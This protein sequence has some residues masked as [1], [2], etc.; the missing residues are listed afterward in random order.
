VVDNNILIE[1]DSVSLS[2]P[3]NNGQP[4]EVFKNLSL[5]IKRGEFV[6]IVGPSGFGKTTLL[7]LVGD[8]LQPT[9]GKIRIDGKTPREA[10]INREF[11]FVFQNPVLLPWQTVRKN[12]ELP[13]ELSSDREVL[14]RAKDFLLKERR[15]FWWTGQKNVDLSQRSEVRAQA[16]KLIDLVGLT[17]FADAYPHQL[18]GGMQSR[19]AIARA[20]SFNPSILLMDEPFGDLDEL[21]REKMNHELLR[22]WRKTQCSV[23]F[24]THSIREAVFLSDRVIVF[25]GGPASRPKDIPIPFERPREHSLRESIEFIQFVSEVRHTLEG[26]TETS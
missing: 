15:L 8:L 24:V 5:G 25:G 1:I 20:L 3:T 18:S 7:R 14:G 2:F 9:K 12:V 26:S 11:S 21:T 6:A 10:R 23:L 17:E 4:L 13:S 16:K 19:V 22:I